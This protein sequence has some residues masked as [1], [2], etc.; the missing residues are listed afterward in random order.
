MLL[1]LSYNNQIKKKKKNKEKKRKEKAEY[2]NKDRKEKIIHSLDYAVLL[3]L[4]STKP[5]L[6]VLLV[7]ATEARCS[8]VV[9]NN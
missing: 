4:I 1:E 8:P 2:Q 7:S 5:T 9:N 3:R 6:K